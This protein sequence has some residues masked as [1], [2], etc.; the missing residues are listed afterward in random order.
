MLLGEIF[1]DRNKGYN[2]ISDVLFLMV[3]S[4][5]FSFF[6]VVL[7]PEFSLN[8]LCSNFLF[9]KNLCLWGVYHPGLERNSAYSSRMRSAVVS[10]SNSAGVDVA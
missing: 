3:Q 1:I 2:G 10:D 5:C 6:I 8:N 4:M 9:Y 7:S